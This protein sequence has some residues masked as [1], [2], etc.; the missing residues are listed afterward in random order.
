[1][2]CSIENYVGGNVMSYLILADSCTDFT[3]EMK[4]REEVVK[5]PLVI[6][7]DGENLVDDENLDAMGFLKRMKASKEVPK[8]ACP[9]PEDY[10]K[11]FGDADEIYVVTISD[12]LSGSYNSAKLALKIYTEEKGE[13]KI[14]IIDSKAGTA[15]E[16]LLVH[17]L[18]ELK[19]EGNS[20]EETV[21][22]IEEFN[23][24]KKVKFVLESLDNLRKN[25]RLTGFK[26]FVAEAL[27]IKPVL[28]ATEEGI[29]GKI[30]QARG[31]N[32]A[33]EMLVEYIVK[34]ATDV[35][36]KNIVISHC[37]NQAGAEKIRDMVLKEKKFK[38]AYVVMTGGISTMYAD[39]G[40][41]VVSY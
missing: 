3:D 23:A 2:I 12:K 13:S 15:A 41:I 18:L 32:K 9:S 11:H 31:I 19:D 40:G 38:K 25:G 21:R 26:A 6:T 34:D 30:G 24:E 10:M 37:N 8:S 22:K 7:V 20:F 39:D 35:E 14:H 5:I 29:I 1:M 33:H 17:R 27:N 16:T 36:N 4:S 28:E